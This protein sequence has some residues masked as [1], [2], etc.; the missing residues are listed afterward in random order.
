[1]SDR[2][3]ERHG[4][5]A[6]DDV[7]RRVA[8]SLAETVRLVDTVARYG[9]TEFVV[10]APG[11]AGLAMAQRAAAAIGRIELG[12]GE[13]PIGVSVGVAVFP[14]DGS[15]VDELLAASERA[16]AEARTRGTAIVSAT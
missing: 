8:A 12:D 10:V 3:A 16:L 4:A 14:T 11:S 13:A 5:H 7:L 15:S 1:M 9:R 6:A 2:I